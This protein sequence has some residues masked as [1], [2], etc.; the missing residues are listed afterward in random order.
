M[1]LA[2]EV[3]S[4]LVTA[5]AVAW[6]AAAGVAAWV[7]CCWG[8]VELRGDG[9]F[10]RMLPNRL[11]NASFTAFL[12]GALAGGGPAMAKFRSELM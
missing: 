8:A 10:V 4:P 7:V 9:L 11:L 3:P 1:R 12:A 2:S 5:G 6:V